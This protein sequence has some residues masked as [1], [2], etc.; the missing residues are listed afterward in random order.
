VDR[1]KGK[2]RSFLLASLKHFLA[3]EWDKSRAQKRGGG[4]TIVSLDAETR[5]RLEPADL[6]SAD[7]V[8]ERRWALTLLDEVLKRLRDEYAAD[9]KTK[10]FEQLKETLTGERTIPYA[11][12]GDRL[13][14][15]EG[16]VKMAVHRLRQRYRETLRAE[17]A[18]TVSAPEEVEEELRH[19]YAALS[20]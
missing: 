12:L 9:G 19:L 8:F 18:Q 13:G 5:Y 7:K 6:V 10:L 3:N 15:R 17:I 1:S 14:M 20:G 2:F 11:K 4:Q 16:A